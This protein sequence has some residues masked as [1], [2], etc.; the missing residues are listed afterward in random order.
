MQ[1]TTTTKHP[2]VTQIVIPFDVAF[3]FPLHSILKCWDLMDVGRGCL[4]TI[5][6]LYGFIAQYCMRSIVIVR[7]TVSLSLN[8]YLPH[9]WAPN[10]V[11]KNICT[12]S[13]S[14]SSCK[15]VLATNIAYALNT[16]EIGWF[17][18]LYE[19]ISQI[20]CRHLN[21]Q[22]HLAFLL[23]FLVFPLHIST[24]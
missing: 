2:N 1:T 6:T 9:Q 12:L 3:N 19:N 13:R 14:R 11:Q 20:V 23:T 22:F 5:W 4:C 17:V 15:S 16:D 10:G 8:S 21:R 18:W 24:I 7:A